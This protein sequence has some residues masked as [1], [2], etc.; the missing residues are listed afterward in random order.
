MPPDLT[1]TSNDGSFAR[2][3]A[4][5]VSTDLSGLAATLLSKTVLADLQ[6]ELGLHTQADI[7][8]ATWVMLQWL[9]SRLKVF[10]NLDY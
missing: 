6:T 5:A 4:T 10:E 2:D 8:A 3:R 1:M 7:N 9:D